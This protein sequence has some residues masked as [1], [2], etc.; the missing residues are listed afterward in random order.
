MAYKALKSFAGAISMRRNEVKEIDDKELAKLLIKGGLV[1]D[2]GGEEKP[3]NIK[4][5]S[6]PA[7]SKGGEA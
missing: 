3:K 5:S 2:L 1:E 7:K 4:S 6:K